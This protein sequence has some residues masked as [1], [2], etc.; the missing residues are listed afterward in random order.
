M[1]SRSC[2]LCLTYKEIQ[3]LSFVK[4]KFHYCAH[5]VYLKRSVNA[6]KRKGPLVFRSH[7]HFLLRENNPRQTGLDLGACQ[8]TSKFHCWQFSSVVV[9]SRRVSFSSRRVQCSV[10]LIRTIKHRNKATDDD[11]FPSNKYFLN[12]IILYVII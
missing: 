4:A 8:N 7:G 3:S 2:R 6:N 9:G 1:C 5:M 12:Y 10:S 11:R